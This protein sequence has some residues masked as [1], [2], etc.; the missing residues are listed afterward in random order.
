M[1]SYIFLAQ[2]AFFVCI[3]VIICIASA[4]SFREMAEQAKEKK[5]REEELRRRKAEISGTTS[6]NRI[7]RLK[8]NLLYN[9]RVI[10][11]P[12]QIFLIMVIGAA[13]VGFFFGKLILTT[14]E[15]SLCMALL[16]AFMP[17][18][19][20]VVR[21][22]WYRQHE[23]DMLE[24][25]MVM[26][27]GSYRACRDII[28]AVKDNI[29]KPN[30]PVAF[31]TFLSDVAFVDSN[32]EKALRKVAAAFRN[33]YFD[34][35]IEVLIKAQYD[36]NM[37]DMLPVIVD[38]MNEAKKAQNESAA[39]MKSV[40]REYAMWVITV[41]CVPL[42]LKVNPEWYNALVNTPFGKVLVVLLLLGLAN[43]MRIMAKIS[44]PIDY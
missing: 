9:L 34:E 38:E 5:Q 15:L 3:L 36:S 44:K 30:I 12:N 25:C 40:W 27:N 17:I 35:W 20:V 8:E 7:Q 39:A 43:T 23:A 19:F 22:N 32:V 31:K 14:F 21:A 13:I 42:V 2:V 6:L 33:R 26:I 24:N 4:N 1:T 11:M 10:K 41:I 29:D 28:K 16:F 37:M 18:I